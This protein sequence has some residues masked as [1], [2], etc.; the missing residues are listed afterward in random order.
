L[1]TIL[2]VAE[3]ENERGLKAALIAARAFVQ[4]CKSFS[5]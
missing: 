4:Q 1:N 3:T 2:T 5:L